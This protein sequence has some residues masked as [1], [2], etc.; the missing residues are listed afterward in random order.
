MASPKCRKA[1]QSSKD[2][3]HEAVKHLL[4]L[5]FE[6]HTHRFIGGTEDLNMKEDAAILSVGIGKPELAYLQFDPASAKAGM[7]QSGIPETIA[8]GYNELFDALNGG[9]YQDGSCFYRPLPGT[10]N[11]GLKTTLSTP[12]APGYR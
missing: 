1:W 6:G 9:M 5:D 10:G 8:D 11:V 4:A 7:M 12:F 3:A 2:I